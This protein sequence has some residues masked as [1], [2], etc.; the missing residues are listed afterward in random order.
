MS[1][2][3]YKVSRFRQKM[4]ELLFKY[5]LE[6]QKLD[7]TCTNNNISTNSTLEIAAILTQ[8]KNSKNHKSD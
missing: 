8:F 7:M 3:T 1:Q 6:E 4:K 5:K 2:V